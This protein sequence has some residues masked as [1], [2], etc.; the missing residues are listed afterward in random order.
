M[1]VSLLLC[2]ASLILWGVGASKGISWVGLVFG[3]GIISC[4]TGIGSSLSIGY[5]LDS[6]KD[7]GGEVMMAVILVRVSTQLVA[8]QAALFGINN[9]LSGGVSMLCET[10][11]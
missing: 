11:L 7:L 8:P 2:P 10:H 1:V 3:M 9:D 6:Y 4:S 5:A